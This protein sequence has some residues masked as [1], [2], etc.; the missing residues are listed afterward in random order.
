M[1]ALIFLPRIVSSDTWI[2]YSRDGYFA[3][4]HL[5][6][7]GRYRLNVVLAE[8]GCGMGKAEEEDYGEES[9]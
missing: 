8:R 7:A 3:D 2:H 9:K 1:L 5:H 4:I 6:G